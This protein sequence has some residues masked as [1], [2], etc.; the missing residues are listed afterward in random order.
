MASTDGRLSDA[1]WT[2]AGSKRDRIHEPLPS[3]PKARGALRSRSVL[4]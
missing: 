2:L 4:I 3:L 1:A